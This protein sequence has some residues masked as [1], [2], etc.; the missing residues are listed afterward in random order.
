MFCYI[1]TKPFLC[2]MNMK[3]CAFGFALT[4]RSQSTKNIHHQASTHYSF[5]HCILLNVFS[6]SNHTRRTDEQNAS[7][8]IRLGRRRRRRRLN[9]KKWSGY[10][11][12]AGSLANESPSIKHHYSIHSLYFFAILLSLLRLWF[13]G[14][15]CDL[16]RL[17][18]L[19]ANVDDSGSSCCLCRLIQQ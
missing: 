14:C 18:R 15:V 13:S 10:Y 4:P 3:Q 8:G 1:K 5:F 9:E 16:F 17:R 6:R 19:S 12:S 2:K 7:Y 11:I